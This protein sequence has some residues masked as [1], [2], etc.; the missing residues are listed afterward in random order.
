MPLL[1]VNIGSSERRTRGL[2][3]VATQGEETVQV[4]D[5]HTTHRMDKWGIAAWGNEK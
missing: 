1:A 5:S 3:Y 2:L 4:R